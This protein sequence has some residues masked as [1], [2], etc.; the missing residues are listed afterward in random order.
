[1][2]KTLI[3]TT[4]SACLLASSSIQAALNLVQDPGFAG[5]ET[6]ILLASS[7]PWVN[8][9]NNPPIFSQPNVAISANA[10]A[11]SGW[12]AVLTS[13]TGE[14]AIIYQQVPLTVGTGYTINFWL[15]DPG[16]PG[17]SV[18]VDLGGTKAGVI[19]VS[20]NSAYTEYNLNATPIAQ[21]ILDFIWV[22]STPPS[23]LEVDDVGVAV[24]EPTTMIAGALMLL[25]FA[26]STLRLRK[27]VSA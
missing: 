19:T 3:F 11:P 23:S 16:Q 13:V 5:G 22:S 20:S 9:Q 15:A 2:K 1:M 10:L 4:A 14:S 24:P 6:G 18:E 21:G 12:N 27:K 26:A 7:S 8:P 25:P 17:G